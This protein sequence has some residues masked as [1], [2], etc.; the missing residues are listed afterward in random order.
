MKNLIFKITIALFPLVFTNCA[1][2]SKATTEKSEEAKSF[3]SKDDKGT[4]YLYRTGRAVGAA[5]QI[6]VKINNIDAGGTGPAT[7]FKW[8]LEPGTY[9]FYSSTGESSAIVQIEIKPGEVHY[10]RQD[11]RLGL[12]KGRV[13]MKEV[14]ANKGQSEVK[15]CKL[16][17]SPY[18]SE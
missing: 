12:D 15:T 13:T 1:S 9:S 2:T 3:E 6:G 8:D 5:G 11:A 7:F 17:I 14:N 16:L 10:I 18:I 4:V